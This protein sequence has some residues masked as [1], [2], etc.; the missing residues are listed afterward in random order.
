MAEQLSITDFLDLAGHHAVIDVRSPSEYEQGHIP[1]AT[2]LPL[3]TDEERAAVG[4]CYKRQGREAA[5]LLGLDLVGPKMRAMASEGMR[6][7]PDGQP[8][9]HCWRGGMRSSSVAW[10]L[11]QI[12]MQ[13]KILVGGYKAFRRAA[14]EEF[15]KDRQMII[16]SGMTGSGKTTMLHR[17]SD[18]GEAVLDLERLANHR[19][20][21][22]GALGLP[23]QP[24]CEQFENELYTRLRKKDPNTPL[25]V[26]DE[27]PSI[28][29]VR[30]PHTFWGKMRE[31]P[32]IFLKVSRE[33][34]AHNLVEEYGD[35]PTAGLADATQRLL[36]KLG[37]PRTQQ[38]LD[39]LKRKNSYEVA[40]DLLEYYDKTYQHAAKRKPREHVFRIDAESLAPEQLVEYSRCHC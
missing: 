21:S 23:P 33:Q 22:F 34:R 13:P 5:V 28:G 17:L 4:T 12:G 38:L 32:A 36:K 1:G 24:T 30:V 37:G 7:C 29:K 18:I 40:F 10:L 26:E 27:S 6:H 15:H 20:S 35:L 8:L 31:S 9:V 25:W 2:N 19:G 3:F 14:L 16:L 39:L 11:E